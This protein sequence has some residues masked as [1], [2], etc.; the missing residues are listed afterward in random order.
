MRRLI[1]AF[2]RNIRNTHILSEYTSIGSAFVVF[3]VV[4]CRPSGNW[5]I[6]K[7]QFF[8][9]FAKQTYTNSKVRLVLYVLTY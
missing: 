8:I 3:V 2:V 4:F 1:C 9:I 5:D 6:V 7:E